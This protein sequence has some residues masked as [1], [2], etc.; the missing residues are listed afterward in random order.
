MAQGLVEKLSQGDPQ[1][2]IPMSV[3]GFAIHKEAGK[4]MSLLRGHAIKEDNELDPSPWKFRHSLCWWTARALGIELEGVEQLDV[5]RE[6]ENLVKLYTELQS[7]ADTG[8]SCPPDEVGEGIPDP[9]VEITTKN[10]E[11]FTALTMTFTEY[12]ESQKAQAKKVALRNDIGRLMREVVRCANFVT[13]TPAM[14]GTQPY[15]SFNAS[16]AQAALFDEAAAMHRT[17]GLMVYGNS[18]RPIFAVGDEKQLPPTLLTMGEIHLETRFS[19]GASAAL[20][21]YPFASAIREFLVDHDGLEL[22]PDTM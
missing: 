5:D 13:V 2:R 4:L 18:M 20:E 16:H 17:D 19:Y 9:E 11:D 8:P 1:L 7:L 15:K 22:P 6:N 21:N 14:A 12:E 3:R 10:F